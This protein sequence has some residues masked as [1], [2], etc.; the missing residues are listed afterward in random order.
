MPLYQNQHY[1]ALTGNKMESPGK[2]QLTHSKLTSRV[3]HELQAFDFRLASFPVIVVGF[4][5]VHVV[6]RQDSTNYPG[7]DRA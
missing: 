7:E 5:I 1:T 6:A 4:V 2:P 3:L